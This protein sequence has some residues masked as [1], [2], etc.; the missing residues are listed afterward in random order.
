MKHSSGEMSD[1]ESENEEG[2]ELDLSNV[3]DIG[4]IAGC[5]MNQLTQMFRCT[6]CQAAVVHLN[7]RHLHQHH[8]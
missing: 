3:R 2:Q 6:L 1:Y 7:A 8:P 5:C 4:P